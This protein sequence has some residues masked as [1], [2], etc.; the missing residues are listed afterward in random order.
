MT[1]KPLLFKAS[2]NCLRNQ[3]YIYLYRF[4]HVCVKVNRN[5]FENEVGFCEAQPLVKGSG[6]D[7]VHMQLAGPECATG[8]ILLL[9]V[10]VPIQVVANGDRAPH[11][12]VASA[13]ALLIAISQSRTYIALFF[14]SSAYIAGCN[15]AR[16]IIMILF[17][18]ALLFAEPCK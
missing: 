12:T 10:G 6:R 18:A 4:M 2:C 1:I 17:S 3:H 7:Y 15:F 8:C 13:I 14:D 5:D 11:S 16:G 9:S